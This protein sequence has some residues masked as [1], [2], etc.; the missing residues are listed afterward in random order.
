MWKGCASQVGRIGAEMSKVHGEKV[1]LVGR[2]RM[3]DEHT[4]EKHT[5]EKH[6]EI[7]EEIARK[8]ARWTWW[9]LAGRATVW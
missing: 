2:V 3:S 7:I 5:V 6:T 8:K 1:R 4:V 9:L